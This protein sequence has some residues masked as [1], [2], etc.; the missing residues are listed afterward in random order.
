MEFKTSGIILLFTCVSLFRFCASKRPLNSYVRHHE[1]L[2]YD[3]SEVHYRAKR[4]MELSPFANVNIKFQ[5]FDKNF[6]MHLT[7]DHEIFA[8]D[9]RIVTSEGKKIDYDYSRFFHGDVEG[10]HQSYV[11]GM[12]NA[13]RFEG[14]IHTLHDEYHIEPA[15]R[16]YQVVQFILLHF[17][18]VQIKN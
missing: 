9:F 10:L 6:S 3:T 14:S 18:I 12:V 16:Y 2:S 17:H 8:P 7:R 13:G 1:L 11:N 4:A 15:E 5:A